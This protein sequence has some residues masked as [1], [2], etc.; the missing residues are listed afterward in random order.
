VTAG[1]ARTEPTTGLDVIG[2]N[3]SIGSWYNSPFPPP[4]V[5]PQPY[6]LESNFAAFNSP[7]FIAFLADW[8]SRHSQ[9]TICGQDNHAQSCR[10]G[11]TSEQPLVGPASPGWNC[12]LADFDPNIAVCRKQN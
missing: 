3:S 8:K 2:I 6:N 9:T 4:S 5:P 1:N 7:Q 12:S 10:A 11:S